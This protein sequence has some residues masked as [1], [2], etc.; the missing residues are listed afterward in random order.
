MHLTFAAPKLSNIDFLNVPAAIHGSRLI[1]SD[2]TKDE[3]PNEL[4]NPEILMNNHHKRIYSFTLI[5]PAIFPD[6]LIS[7]CA[8][9]VLLS[10]ASSSSHITSQR[11]FCHGYVP[12][13]RHVPSPCASIPLQQTFRKLALRGILRSALCASTT[14]LLLTRPVGLS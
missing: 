5:L 1:I 10:E 2:T 3:S 7:S 6:T 9:I 12:G 13:S 11:S 8:C 4:I 14:K